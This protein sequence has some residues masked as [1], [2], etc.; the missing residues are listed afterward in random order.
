MEKRILITGGADFLGSN[1]CERLFKECNDIISQ[2]VFLRA[3]KI[4]SQTLLIPPNL[5]YGY[6]NYGLIVVNVCFILNVV[7]GAVI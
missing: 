1:F 2:V 4:I 3:L 6:I 5:G 7:D